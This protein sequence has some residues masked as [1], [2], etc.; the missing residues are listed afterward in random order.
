MVQEQTTEAA[1]KQIFDKEYNNLCRYAYTY[2]Q[3]E[4]LAEDVVQDTFIR[5]WEQKKE[6]I[7][8]DNIR[9]YLVTSVRNNC[10]SEL[11]KNKHL[12]YPENT[13]QTEPEPFFSQMLH[14][15][16]YNEQQQRIARA[17]DKLPP[18]CKEVFLLVKLHGMSYKQ[19]AATLE[20]S[21]KTVENQM[22]KAI[23]IFQNP[24]A[25]LV[26][27][28]SIILMNFRPGL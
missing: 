25:L 7:V 1:F 15:E 2:L 26:A 4:H 23:K 10:I 3:D 6:L 19:A 27:F 22:G 17:L 11:R 18:K 9:Y 8:T 21:V 24:V 20:I 28:C 12:H 16:Q 14:K 13:P 5:I